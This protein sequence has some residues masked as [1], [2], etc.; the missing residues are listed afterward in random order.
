[1]LLENF[2]QMATREELRQKIW[3]ADTKRQSA[4]DCKSRSG[5]RSGGFEGLNGARFVVVDVEDFEE[6]RESSR[7]ARTLGGT[8]DSF[9]WPLPW[10]IVFKAQINSLKPAG[11]Q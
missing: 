11:V 3:P 2:G 5:K 8:F 9:S 1:M 4:A 6:V 7:P 10:C